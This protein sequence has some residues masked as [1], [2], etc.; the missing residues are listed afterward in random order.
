MAG[1]SIDFVSSLSYS[2][3]DPVTSP[4][5]IRAIT[6][7]PERGMASITLIVMCLNVLSL[8]A[9]ITV[10]PSGWDG[11]STNAYPR[12]SDTHRSGVPDLCV[13]SRAN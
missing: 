7:L 13:S 10:L 3:I 4:G 1:N 12:S 5:N 8:R 6:F 9:T 2:A 11:I